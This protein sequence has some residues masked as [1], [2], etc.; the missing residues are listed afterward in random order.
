[1]IRYKCDSFE[2]FKEYKVEVKRQT[3]KQIKVLRLD[4]G[5]ENLLGKFKDYLVHHGIVSQLMGLETPQ[6]NEEAKK[7]N[8]TLLEMARRMMSHASLPICFWGYVL[9][10]AEYFLNL[11]SS[12]SVPKTPYVTSVIFVY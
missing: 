8:K 2:K 11:E 12:K 5:G 9:E 10:I 7:R 1:L 4:R 3:D 6:Q